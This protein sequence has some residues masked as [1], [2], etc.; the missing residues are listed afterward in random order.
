MTLESSTRPGYNDRS[1]ASETTQHDISPE[2]KDRAEVIA[3]VLHQITDLAIS[4]PHPLTIPEGVGTIDNYNKTKLFTPTK[5]MLG[6]NIQ[7]GRFPDAILVQSALR[8]HRSKVPDTFDSLMIPTDQD[9]P[10][11]PE[12]Y[13]KIL[14]TEESPRSSDSAATEQEPRLYDEHLVGIEAMAAVGHVVFDLCRMEAFVETQKANK[15]DRRFW[16]TQITG[17]L[18]SQQT[19]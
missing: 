5:H 19:N 8:R 1:Q 15:W 14:G 12:Y 4:K 3:D 17:A 7:V 6:R 16:D 11:K 10:S 18:K 13:R 9:N 2:I